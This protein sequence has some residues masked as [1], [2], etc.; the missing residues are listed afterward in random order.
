MCFSCRAA[1]VKHIAAG[2]ATE[3]PLLLSDRIALLDY[4]WL[5]AGEVDLKVGMPTKRFIEGFRPTVL[6][7]TAGAKPLESSNCLG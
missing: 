5:G 2:M 1:E 7:C 3:L 6:D 4:F